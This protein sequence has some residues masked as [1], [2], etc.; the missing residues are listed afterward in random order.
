VAELLEALPVLPEGLSSAPEERLRLMFE[1][2]R[3]SVRY[4]KPTN[5]AHI[6]VSISEDTVEQVL[7]NGAFLADG[8]GEGTNC[9]ALVC[10]PGRNRTSDTRFR[11]PVLYPLSYEGGTWSNGRTKLH[12]RVWCSGSRGLAG[13]AKSNEASSRTNSRLQACSCF[14]PEG[15]GPKFPGLG[16]VFGGHPE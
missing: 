7:G 14:S 2:F 5:V 6:R 11:K 3:L 8:G 13:P 15:A 12:R 1:C 4:K 9:A 10:A 16:G